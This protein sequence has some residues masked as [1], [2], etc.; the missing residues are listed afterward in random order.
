MAAAPGIPSHTRGKGRPRSF[1]RDIALFKALEIFW[2]RGYEPASIADLC[3][4]MG[5]N[6]PSLYAAFGN[7]ANLFL[8]AVTFYEEHY[9]TAPSLRFMEEK[10]FYLAVYNFFTEAAGILLSPDLPCG[11]M[12]VLAA[13]NIS[14]QEE[15][16]IQT[17]RRMRLATK[18]MFAEKIRLAVND[19]QLPSDTD[20]ETL[21]GALNTYLEGL[22]LQA[23]DGLSAEE[24]RKAASYAV[25]MLPKWH[26][27]LKIPSEKN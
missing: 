9:W 24:L 17:L 14:E 22:S 27:R 10:D 12:V 6:A 23:R 21:A 3:S 16:I 18:N 15:E 19:G 1:D 7:K 8:E 4:A 11:C 20:T 5:I 2:R 26:K 13:V 25:H